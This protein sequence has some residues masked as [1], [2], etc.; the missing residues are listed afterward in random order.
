[1][2]PGLQGSIMLTVWQGTTCNTLRFTRAGDFTIWTSMGKWG[3]W[4]SF[5]G[6]LPTK[7]T[8]RTGYSPSVTFWPLHIFLAKLYSFSVVRSNTLTLNR[9]LSKVQFV[10][11]LLQSSILVMSPS[12]GMQLCYFKGI[13]LSLP[14]LF[15][16]IGRKFSWD[17]RTNDICHPNCSML[18]MKMGA[19]SF[20]EKK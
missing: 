17:N 14:T 4:P 15:T 13:E 2:S 18:P 3:Q 1:M 10:Q 8:Q 9:P 19:F 7:A 20:L 11:D 5:G 12:W 16:K 6:S